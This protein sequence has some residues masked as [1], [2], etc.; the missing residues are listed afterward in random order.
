M[1]LEAVISSPGQSERRVRGLSGLLTIGRGAD[2]NIPLESALV[3]RCHVTVEVHGAKMRVYDSSRNGTL[4]GKQF[5]N[6]A[7]TEVPVGTALTVETE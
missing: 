5:V 3:S 1:Q 2:C 6:N 4:A 7:M